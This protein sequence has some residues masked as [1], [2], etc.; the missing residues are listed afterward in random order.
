MPK[1]EVQSMADKLKMYS[2]IFSQ[3]EI[4]SFLQLANDEEVEGE[5][6]E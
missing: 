3:N 5:A 2:S 6:E 4:N 1:Q